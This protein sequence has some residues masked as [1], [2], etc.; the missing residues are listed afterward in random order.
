MAAASA[1]KS[2]ACVCAVI[3]A[4]GFSTRMKAF[5]PL[6]PFGRTSVLG[7]VVASWKA[8]GVADILVV[9][10]HNAALVA[11]ECDRLGT[12][13]A[14]NP[15]PEDGMF[16]SVRTGLL[17]GAGRY[18]GA[19]WFGVHPVD[20]P[21][22]RPSTLAS[23]VAAAAEPGVELLVPVHGTDGC[24]RQGH[25]PLLSRALAADVCAWRGDGG[26]RAALEGVRRGT[27][28]VDDPFLDSDMDEPGDY[29]RAL[30]FLAG[31]GDCPV[32]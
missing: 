30:A 20:I 27:V 23:L 6:L 2:G 13:F 24:V 16:S 12:A 29:E 5:K 17:A 10:G 9:A 7:H 18:P 11:R 22:V 15:H 19:G 26:L 3:L 25:P 4:A 1:G 28:L 14:V 31:E 32:S 21:L 8:A